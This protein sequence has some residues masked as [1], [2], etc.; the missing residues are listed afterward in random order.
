MVLPPDVNSTGGSF[1]VPADGPP[2]ASSPAP[3][4]SPQQEDT[5]DEPPQ[6]LLPLLTEHLS[7]CL[8]SRARAVASDEESERDVREWDKLI[9]AYLALLAQWLWEE[10]GSVREFLESG[11]MGMVSMFSCLDD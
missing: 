9:V 11:G 4:P 5:D 6:P 8:L 10:P 3:A 2:V 7:L 1:F